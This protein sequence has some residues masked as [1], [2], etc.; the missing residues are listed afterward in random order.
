LLAR[1]VLRSTAA[2]QQ[3][4]SLTDLLRHAT[5]AWHGVK[6]GQPDWAPYS[7]ALAFGAEMPA[8]RMKLHLIMNAYWEPLDF[9]LPAPDGDRLW[10]RWIDTALDSPDDIAPW[11]EAPIWTADSYRAEARIRRGALGAA[12]I[13]RAPMTIGPG[14]RHRAQRPPH[15]RGQQ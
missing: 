12:R 3:R 14:R 9:E 4:V 11:Q 15:A 13:H 8:A 2:E 10:R 1:R 6:L 7:H 5:F